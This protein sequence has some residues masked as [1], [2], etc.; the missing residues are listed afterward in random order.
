MEWHQ[1][2]EKEAKGK[3]GDEKRYAREKRTDPKW[4]LASIE[5]EKLPLLENG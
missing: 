2:G 3:R 5:E 4:N 1:D